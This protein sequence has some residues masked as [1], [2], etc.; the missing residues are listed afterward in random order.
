M[1]SST[2]DP[3]AGGVPAQRPPSRRARAWP[4]RAAPTLPLPARGAGELSG[5]GERMSEPMEAA[6]EAGT[7]DPGIGGVPAQ[8][9][10][11]RRARAWPD[12]AAPTLP[13]PARGAGEL[14]GD[15]ERM[16]EPME[17]A[18]EA[19]TG[20][21]GIGG[22]PAQRPPS[23]RA[24][25]W[26]GSAARRAGKASRRQGLGIKSWPESERPREKLLRKGPGALS[27]AELLA[28]FVRSGTR[29]RN[30]VDLARE[31]IATSGSLR[32]VLELTRDDLCRL[33]G[34]G[35]ARYVELQACLELGRRHLAMKLDRGRPITSSGQTSRFLVAKLR[36]HPFEVF[37]CLF[38]DNRH[39]VIEF[40]ELFRG[41]IDRA[42]VHPREV[43]RR[44]LSHNAA[45]VIL[46]HNHPSGIAEP[47]ATDLVLT[48]QLVSA[49]SL[50]GV[51][52]L[53]HFIVGDG[54]CF[55][56][57]EHGLLQPSRAG[58]RTTRPGNCS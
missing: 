31:A 50:V 44:S 41:T 9:P 18:I 15:G 16:S 55:S 5:D 21:P 19:G 23:R 56:F 32:A 30:A 8:R 24:R 48:D 1:E 17:A 13:L 39:R 45:A 47:S 2:G 52:V 40:E 53:D 43:V 11:S 38:L 46:A 42:S 51:E 3:G 7:G 4:G 14:S 33:P 36:H 12:S 35:L 54:E 57:M 58:S 10:P 20:D 37:G 22:V 25:G 49:L 29:G 27:D 34:F 26:P 6:I 28:L